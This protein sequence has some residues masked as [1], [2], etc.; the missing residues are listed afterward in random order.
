MV[1]FCKNC[2]Y[3]SKD[4][5]VCFHPENEGIRAFENTPSCKY[6]NEK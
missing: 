6:Y 4:L 5:Y 1:D 3:Y 2:K